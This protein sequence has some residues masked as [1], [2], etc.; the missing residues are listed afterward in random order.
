MLYFQSTK[1]LESALTLLRAYKTKYDEK[2]SVHDF[3]VWCERHN[4]C[5]LT[6]C[7]VL[8]FF[9]LQ[10]S[11]YKYVNQLISVCVGLQRALA[12]LNMPQTNTNNNNNNNDNNKIKDIN[13][14]NSTT[15]L[16]ESAQFVT[17]NGI[18]HVKSTTIT[19]QF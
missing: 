6:D 5:K 4:L 19:S 8:Y 2:L 15:T 16:L 18:D 12:R 17:E 13:S 9:P 7:L 11:N 14:N 10:P 3:D 1:Q